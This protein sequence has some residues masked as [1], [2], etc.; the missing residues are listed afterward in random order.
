MNVGDQTLIVCV[1]Y[2]QETVAILEDGPYYRCRFCQ[3]LCLTSSEHYTL[4]GA[5]NLEDL[6]V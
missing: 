5:R 4:D 3:C 1:A 2:D 6:L